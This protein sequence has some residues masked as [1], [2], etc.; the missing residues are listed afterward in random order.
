MSAYHHKDVIHVESVTLLVQNIKRSLAFYHDILGLHVHELGPHSIGL[1]A[2]QKTILITLNED[3]NA[4]PLGLNLGLY[5]YALL[6]SSRVE[7]AK[8]VKQLKD[9]HYPLTGASDHGVSEAIYLDDP[10]GHGIEIYV[11][12]PS[13]VWPKDKGN[14]TMFTKSLDFNSLMSTLEVDKGDYQ[15][16]PMMIMG[17]LHLHVAHLK[18]AKHF[19][20]DALGFQLVMHYGQSAMFISDEGY[21]HHIGLNTWQGDAQLTLEKQVGLKSYVL[22]IP[23]A[24][25]PALM[26]RL[27]DHHVTAI[28]D[29]ETIYILDPLNQKIILSI[30]E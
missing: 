12:R 30:K 22:S 14:I 7:L 16:D 4:L 15:I 27:T 8:V 13:D 29:Q 25:Y 26:R 19:F 1:S 9:K 17:H 2:D 11:D 5:H 24:K 21:H 28:K 6:V 3:R 10:D 18:D 20:V 23:K